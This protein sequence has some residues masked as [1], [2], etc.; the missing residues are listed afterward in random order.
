MKILNIELN[1]NR[2]KE[3]PDMNI[4]ENVEIHADRRTL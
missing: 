2:E 3:D 1:P 4:K